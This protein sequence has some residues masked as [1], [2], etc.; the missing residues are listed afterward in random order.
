MVNP[1]RSF[2][3]ALAGMTAIATCLLC[4]LA[5]S[6]VMAQVTSKTD[7]ADGGLNLVKNGSF[8]ELDANG[9]PKGWGIAGHPGME[10]AITL[11]EGPVGAAKK[12]LKLTCTKFV[13]GL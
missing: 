4:V 8:D 10:Q 7:G 5:S 1:R 13:P 6:L 9:K 3:L 2:G 12:A 11:T